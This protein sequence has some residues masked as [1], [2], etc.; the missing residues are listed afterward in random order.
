MLI[1]WRAITTLASIWKRSI[2]IVP[3]R[4]LADEISWDILAVAIT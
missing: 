4:A 2:S 3:M 1:S